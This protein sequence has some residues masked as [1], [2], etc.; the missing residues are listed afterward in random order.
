MRV[1]EFDQTGAFGMFQNAGLEADLPHVIGAA[2]GRTGSAGIGN[3]HNG[4]S[5]EVLS[6]DR[7]L[8]TMTPPCKLALFRV[9]AA[10]KIQAL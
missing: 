10:V 7:Y 2:A 8:A 1:A 3:C 6:L 9:R 4:T 5:L